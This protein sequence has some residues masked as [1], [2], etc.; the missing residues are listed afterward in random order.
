[1]SG[2]ERSGAAAGMIETPEFFELMHSILDTC[3][4]YRIACFERGYGNTMSERMTL[5]FH[6]MLLNFMFA[7]VTAA[8]GRLIER[9]LEL[10]RGYLRELL[11]IYDDA[12]YANFLTYVAHVDRCDECEAGEYMC[13]TGFLLNEDF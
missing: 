12:G 2:S 5:A 9:E 7:H 3:D 4:A 8:T 1:V 13:E 6:D 10:L 11:G